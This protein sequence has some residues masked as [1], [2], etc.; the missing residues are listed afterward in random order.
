LGVQEKEEDSSSDH[1]GKI[2]A[3]YMR[4]WNAKKQ[5]NARIKIEQILLDMQDEEA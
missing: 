4:P 1:F 3:N 2:V 5:A